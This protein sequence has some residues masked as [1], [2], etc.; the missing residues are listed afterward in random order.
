MQELTAVNWINMHLYTVTPIHIKKKSVAG[1]LKEMVIALCK[2]LG[3]NKP[4][5][6][7]KKKRLFIFIYPNKFSITNGNEEIKTE[8]AV[9][10]ICKCRYSY[11]FIFK[12]YSEDDLL[13]SPEFPWN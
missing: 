4:P 12:G 9:S 6:R 7:K 3:K 10:A 2:E 11:L 13:H 8:Q 5:Q 1:Y